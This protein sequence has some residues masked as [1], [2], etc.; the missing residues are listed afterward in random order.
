M[1]NIR[2]L[3]R[4]R[5]PALPL[6]LLSLFISLLFFAPRIHLAKY[7]SV[8]V[9]EEPSVPDLDCMTWNHTK[10]CPK[11]HST[12][13][14]AKQQ[15][16]SDCPEYFRWIHEDLRHWR[17]TGIAEEMVAEARRSAHFRLTILDGRMYVEKF[18]EAFQSRGL[19]TLWGFAQLMARYGGKLP[20]LELMFN[21]DDRPVVEAEQYEAA[22]KIPPPLFKYCADNRTFDIVFPDWTFWGWA[23]LN[24]Q[25]WSSF[26]KEMK[27]GMDNL[28]WEDRVPYAYWKG[29]HKVSSQRYQLMQCNLTRQNDW[30]ARLYSVDWEEEKRRGFKQSNLANQCSHRYK[31]YAEGWG[32]SVSK[33]YILSCNS[34]TLLI[35]S[36]WHDFFTR[37]LIPQHHYWPV[38]DTRMCRSIKLAVEWGNNHTAMAKEIG[39][40]GSRFAHEALEMENVYGYMFHLLNE[41][42]KLFKYKPK[43]PP[44][45]TELCSELL[46]CPADGKWREFMEETM[47]NSP[48]DSPPCKMPP[49]FEPRDLGA[50]AVAKM[51]AVNEVEAWEDEYWRKQDYKHMEQ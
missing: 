10:K 26:L 2:L 3:L 11:H 20:D 43:I 27:Q 23:E 30:N 21:C 1:M 44:N 33:K 45:A 50:F 36:R 9:V 4:P 42:A 40:A 16:G 49:P 46:A 5:A 34:P 41:Y 47:E 48:S 7:D 28:K 25:P 8:I 39:E 38:R 17:N 13:S 35:Q 14:Q 31:I 18:A 37:G 19:F 32:W 51:E 15:S 29:N 24:I 6:L 22:G 12:F